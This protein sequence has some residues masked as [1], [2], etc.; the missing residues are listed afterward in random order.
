MR[1]A[2]RPLWT[3]IWR[4]G[5]VAGA[6]G[7]IPGLLNSWETVHGSGR[8]E[9]PATIHILAA[10]VH[11]ET[12]FLLGLVLALVV[13]L[14][15]RR[16]RP[17]ESVL[18]VAL[19]LPLVAFAALGI[20]INV[21]YLPQFNSPFSLAADAALMLICALG[22][23]WLY[24]RGRARSAPS[25]FSRPWL[26]LVLLVLVASCLAS[27]LENR[28]SVEEIPL[29]EARADQPD[30]LFLLVDTVRADHLSAYGYP[31]P[32]TPWLE[33]LA[34]EGVLFDEAIAASCHTKPSTASIFTARFP[35][36]HQARR[37][38]ETL[39]ASA[40]TLTQALRAVGYRTAAFSANGLVSPTFGF[41]R[42]FERFY[43]QEA[44][45]MML[46]DLSEILYRL[47]LGVPVAGYAAGGVLGTFLGWEWLLMPSRRASE[48]LLQKPEHFEAEGIFTAAR[49]WLDEVEGDRDHPVFTYVHLLEPH[50]PYEPPAALQQEYE[51]RL[52]GKTDDPYFPHYVGGFLPFLRGDPLPPERRLGLVARYNA[53]I[54]A[55]DALLASFVQ[56][57]RNRRPERE[58]LLV[59]VSD[60]GE[61]FYEHGGWGHGHSLYEET[62]RVPLVLHY[63]GHLPAGRRVSE[64]VSLIDL[65][66]TLLDL[67]D[68]PPVPA[69]QGTSL[70]PTLEG[71]GPASRSPVFSEIFW[72]GH[73]AQSISQGSQKLIRATRGGEVRTFLFDLAADPGEE[74][75]RMELAPAL[76]QRL[77]QELQ[78]VLAQSQA[79][80]V[81]AQAVRIEGDIADQMRALGYID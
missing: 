18:P 13:G 43:R 25:H 8:A 50:D 49:R 27:W 35:P 14:L 28:S 54:A 36:A 72:G 73:F 67:I 46:L 3:L 78:Q 64:R 63:P 70:L 10:I 39:P 23:V 57:V 71:A 42:G 12:F 4:T 81:E 66:P 1:T 21:R 16:R 41:G 58:L 9:V 59:V 61:E 52:G 62:I 5:L 31:H 33:A 53:E 80:A 32:T 77:D 65:G 20:T 15:W 37:L 79:I 7:M 51:G 17:A 34:A 24:R 68:V 69:F 11:G 38:E 30:L 19:G 22:G 55:T 26:G 75:N 45:Y 74:Q 29:G 47:Y 44:P 6:V 76:G 60:H 2:Q 48:S 56:E 40:F